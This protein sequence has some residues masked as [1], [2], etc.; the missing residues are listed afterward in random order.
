MG[1][2]ERV[3][4]PGSRDQMRYQ[5]VLRLAEQKYKPGSRALEIGQDDGTFALGL[6]GRGYDV[7]SISP[8]HICQCWRHFQGDIQNM[9]LDEKFDLIHCGQ[10]L[11]HLSDPDAAMRNICRMA[12][13]TTLIIVSVPDFKDPDHLRTYR[14]DTFYPWIETYMDIKHREIFSVKDHTT[15]LA[16]GVMR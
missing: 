15:F 6:V 14:A 16:A 3:N 5:T 2:L 7:T 13:K 9:V 11:E 4:T 10:V 1:L 12:H 8:D